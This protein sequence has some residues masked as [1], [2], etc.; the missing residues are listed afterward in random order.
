M[1]RTNKLA[2]PKPGVVYNPPGSVG[3]E[4]IKSDAFAVGILGPIGSGKS[5]ACVMKLVRN[6]QKQ[7][8]LRDGWIRRR[9]AVIRNTFPEL[10]TTTIKTWHQWIDR[11]SV[12]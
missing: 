8:R 7:V 9:T 12:V 11:K 2:D 1:A 3:R 6:V 10:R 5:V 4:F